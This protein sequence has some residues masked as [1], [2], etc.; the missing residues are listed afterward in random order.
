[1]PL[2]MDF[3]IIPDVTI[4]D[5]KNAHMA[6]E[7]VQHKYGVKYHQFWVNE[8]AGTVFCL[9][10]GPDK[11][12]CIATHQEAHGNVACKIEEVE[13]GLYNLFLGEKKQIDHGLVRHKDG[14]IDVG[15]RY[16]LVVD[17][18]GN[19]RIKT[20]RDYTELRL[21]TKAKNFVYQQI[22]EYQGKEIKLKGV[23]SLVAVFTTPMEALECALS[24]HNKLVEK[25]EATNDLEWDVSFKMGL[26]GG[27]PLTKSD[28]FFEKTIKQARR[29]SLI[30]KKGEI[31][32]SSF[33]EQMRDLKNLIKKNPNINWIMVSDENFID[34]LFTITE[35]SIDKDDFS[36]NYLSR[37]L[38]I[39]LPQLYRKIISITGKSP[40]TFIRDIRM[41]KAFFLIKEKRYNI[42]EV[43][44]Q[45]GFNNPSYFAKC[46][47]EKFGLPPSK[48]RI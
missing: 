23:D 31:L 8:E 37:D 26:S 14:A 3:H 12:A 17:I 38:G 41:R 33:V 43:A 27:Q 47:Q 34:S 20:S 16:V 9:I 45:V 21:P 6:D 32:I 42:S 22:K 13:P 7:E 24:I 5:V 36:V 1:M 30:A 4:E 25:K 39:S 48:L 2:Y 15:Y 19:T 10:E 29:L 11:E 35:N 46:F 28:G 44:L 18:V 40:K